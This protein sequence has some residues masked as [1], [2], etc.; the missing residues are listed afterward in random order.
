MCGRRREWPI[1]RRRSPTH[2]SVT[3][4]GRLF[5]KDFLLKPNAR[6]I[7]GL[8]RL[9]FFR[10]DTK[11]AVPRF[12][13]TAFQRYLSPRHN[14]ERRERSPVPDVDNASQFL[15]LDAHCPHDRGSGDDQHADS[16]NSKEQ[17][18]EYHSR[19]TGPATRHFSCPYSVHRG[20]C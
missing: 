6:V 2:V 15:R 18:C 5:V 12:L 19:N 14:R 7:N 9:L 11:R 20:S 17:T 3:A 13:Y 1:G 16:D 10:C 8:P 4:Y